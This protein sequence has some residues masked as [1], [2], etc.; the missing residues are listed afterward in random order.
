MVS[1]TSNGRVSRPSLSQ[2]IER[3]DG[4]LDGL[5]EA[6]NESVADAVRDV[7]GQA[8]QQA[9]ETTLREVL[10][11]PAV[12]RSALAQHEP[13]PSPPTPPQR[14]GTP[15]RDLLRGMLASLVSQMGQQA[16]RV[17][18]TASWLWRGSVQRLGQFVSLLGHLGQAAGAGLG[19]VWRYRRSGLLTV[20]G[21]VATGL[22]GY[23]GGP[24]VSA[25]LCGLAGAGLTLSALVVLPLAR[26]LL[27]SR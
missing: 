15:L 11:N 23:L 9:V 13:P 10:G 17:Q 27:A 12:L 1:S 7:V 6:L 26:I 22:T 21:G 20:V 4:I 8:V 24:L 25:V 5:A 19:Q 14:T 16:E 18:Q 3:L 2:Q